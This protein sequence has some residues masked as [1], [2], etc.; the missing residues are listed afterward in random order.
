[1]AL[2]ATRRCSFVPVRI[3]IFKIKVFKKK[4]TTNMM[5]NNE[6]IE[7]LKVYALAVGMAHGI[8]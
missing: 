7:K 8:I 3:D 4:P 5:N 2:K 6:A 1:M